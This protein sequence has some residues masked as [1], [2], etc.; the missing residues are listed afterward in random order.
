MPVQG[1]ERVTIESVAGITADADDGGTGSAQ[2]A[3]IAKEVRCPGCGEAFCVVHRQQAAHACSAPEDFNDRH[4]AFLSRRTHALEVLARTF[5]DQ[6]ARS[7]PKPPPQRDVVRPPSAMTTSRGSDQPPTAVSSSST[8]QTQIQ[9]NG[10]TKSKAEKLYDMHLRK[11]RSLAKP[12]DPKR[13]DG[14]KRF[15]EWGIGDVENARKWADSGKWE[16][17]K[18]ERSWVLQETPTG[19]VLD[20]LIAASKTSR[21]ISTSPSEPAQT[22][23]LVCLSSPPDVPRSL[24]PLDLSRSAGEQIFEG[25]VILLVRGWTD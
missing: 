5:P 8:T 2:V 7:I 25:C 11:L 16:G 12:L 13:R 9:D 6:A 10:K 20:L 18:L 19:K 4:E 21:P 17:G 3:D 24:A 22:L 15:F 23:S 14:E 1:C